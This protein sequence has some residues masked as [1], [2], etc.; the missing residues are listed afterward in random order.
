M[1][2]GLAGCI[3]TGKTTTAL[4]IQDILVRGHLHGDGVPVIRSFADG[5][6]EKAA[7][8]YNFPLAW[9]YTE[10]GKAEKLT[11]CEHAT[12]RQAL[13]YVGTDL[14]RAEDPDVWVK[15]LRV[16]TAQ[17][18]RRKNFIILD[19]IRFPNECDFVLEHGGLL[20]HMKPYQGWTAGPNAGHISENALEDYPHFTVTFAPR[21]GGLKETARRICSLLRA[22]D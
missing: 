20:V 4:Y 5:V 9:A 17:D 2:I 6:K 18:L 11:G 3:G 14:C 21:M 19:D 10:K 16:A 15:A 12:V 22:D 8:M 13:Q 1:I 7:A